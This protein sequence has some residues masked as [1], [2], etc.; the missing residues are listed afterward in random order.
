M[1]KQNL[2]TLLVA[3]L[4][5][6]IL[7]FTSTVYKHR[8]AMKNIVETAVATEQFSTLVTAVKAAGLPEESYTAPTT[9]TVAPT[10]TVTQPATA[11]T[12][13]PESGLSVNEIQN[14]VSSIPDIPTADEIL[15]DV[16][17]SEEFKLLQ[18]KLGLTTDYATA[19][20][21]AAKQT[22]ETKY[23]QDKKTFKRYT[24]LYRENG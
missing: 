13:M 23:G 7:G 10:P 6:S 1:K 24:T 17:G 8:P 16:M 5:M 4:V 21:E 3:I 20:A 12:K 2:T 15:A 14:I 9:P 18:E 22:L 19:T 11:E